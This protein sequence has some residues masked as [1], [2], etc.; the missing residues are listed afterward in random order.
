MTR[1]VLMSM[2][3]PVIFG[4]TADS[5]IPNPLIGKLHPR[6]TITSSVN[7]SGTITPFGEMKVIEN[8]NQTYT[9]FPSVGYKFDSLIIDGLKNE[10][11]DSSYSFTNIYQNHS[12]VP[13]FSK[14]SFTVTVSV[15]DTFGTASPVGTQS[16]LYGNSCGVTFTPKIGCQLD[17]V[18]LDGTKIAITGN[19][20]TLM[21]VTANHTVTSYFG[22]IPMT[23]T[24]NGYT[25][26]GGTISPLGA[27]T[28]TSGGSQKFVF[29]ANSGN[30]LDSVTVDGVNTTPVHGTDASLT[31][32]NVTVNKT[33]KAWYSEMILS[34][35]ESE[36]LTRVNDL[37]RTGC[38]CGTVEMPPVS[39]VTWNSILASL[40]KKHS[41][42]MI[43]R[44]YFAH[45]TPDFVTFSQRITNGGY[46][47]KTAGE[48]IS[49]GKTTVESVISAWIL[50]EGECRN[51]MNSNFTEMGVGRVD[52]HWTQ[53]FATPKN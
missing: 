50:T 17:S 3:L 22:K 26:A 15:A 23:Y 11:Y 6:Y 51:I 42:D 44:N 1:N 35:E 24:L 9:Y 2:A 36:L 41:Q 20:Y 47:W 43:S 8:R 28:V 13:Y 29:H 53:V 4:C 27:T 14:K 12:I 30:K 25:T 10:N 18:K 40:A 16:I 5:G 21:N 34:I 45:T 49:T 31:L 39:S 32:T 37:R 46:V 33:V 52:N 48:N 7:G 19:N 38:L